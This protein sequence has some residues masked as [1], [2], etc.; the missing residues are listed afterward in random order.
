MAC[1]RRDRVGSQK[2]VSS[3]EH[4]QDVVVGVAV[5]PGVTQPGHVAMDVF[6]WGESFVARKVAQLRGGGLGGVVAGV[7]ARASR[8]A[9][10]LVRPDSSRGSADQDNAETIEGNGTPTVT[11]SSATSTT[12]PAT[13]WAAGIR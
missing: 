11:P 13:I 5:L 9:V 10:Q 12:R 1:T 6:G 8:I 4:G 2:M 7:E 3:R